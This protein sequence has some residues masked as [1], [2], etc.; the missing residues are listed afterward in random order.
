MRFRQGL[1]LFLLFLA[2]NAAPVTLAADPAPVFRVGETLTYALKWGPVRA[3]T[4]VMAVRDTV[5]VDGRAC[6]HVVS[7]AWSN[8]FFSVFY[9]VE[10][11]V[12]T[13]IDVE[14]LVPLRHE[15]HLSEGTYHQD[16]TIVFDHGRGMAQYSDGE[17]VEFRPGVQDIL[18]ALYFVRS[19][20][21]SQK[22]PILI[23]NQ[24]N[25]K[26]YTLEVRV[27]QEEWVT[28]PSGRYH[29]TVIEPF[30]KATGLFRQEGRLWIW[31]TND[32]HRIPVKMKSKIKV[33]SITALLESVSWREGGEAE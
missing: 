6:F 24:T 20:K 29:C 13:W 2:A 15:K 3:G 11:R 22:G 12:E 30:L 26:N 7:E 21:F 9:P 16:E 25:R 23:E 1:R 14:R 4:A 31:L 17:W 8:A 19:L 10:D 28:T 33:G 27:L 5:R 32:E 18:S